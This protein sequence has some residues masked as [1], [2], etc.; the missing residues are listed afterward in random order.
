M[1]DTYNFYMQLRLQLEFKLQTKA[2][3]LSTAR[4]SACRLS[5]LLNVSSLAQFIFRPAAAVPFDL[6]ASVHAEHLAPTKAAYKTLN[7]M[8]HDAFCI[9]LQPLMKDDESQ[10]EKPQTAK[11]I[12]PNFG[13]LKFCIVLLFCSCIVSMWRISSLKARLD[14]WS[15]GHVAPTPPWHFGPT[16][17]SDSLAWCKTK[18]ATSATSQSFATK[19]YLIHPDPLHRDMRNAVTSPCH[20]HSNLDPDSKPRSVWRRSC[21][22]LS[23]AHN[24]LGQVLWCVHGVSMVCPV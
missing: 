10:Y 19:F 17:T 23:L 2:T 14:G 8:L 15:P 18:V 1:I 5:G 13:Q 3:S 7:K 6:V 9:I 22:T 4:A 24:D 16:S 11:A 21:S 12:E 20:N